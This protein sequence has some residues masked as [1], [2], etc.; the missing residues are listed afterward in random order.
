ME[1]T[2]QMRFTPPVQT[3]YAFRQ[4]INEYFQEGSINR[5]NRYAENW[6]TLR[7]GLQNLG[8]HL[9]LN[10]EDES[11]ILL[12]VIEPENPEYDFR[13]KLSFS[14]PRDPNQTS[15]N[16]GDEDYDPLFPYGYGLNYQ[17]DQFIGDL[18]E[19]IH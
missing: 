4:A 13:G 9:L 11:H 17:S 14:W 7:N 16:L 5:Y 1:K 6:H 15:L 19:T 12:T 10:P 2:G 8:F 18:D 3:I